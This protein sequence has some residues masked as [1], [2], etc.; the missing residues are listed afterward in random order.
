MQG[1]LTLDATATGTTG[2]PR[3]AGTARLA[4]GSVQDYAQGVRVTDITALIVAA[5]DTVRIQSF[6]GHAGPG[7][8]GLSGSV[9]VLAPGLPVD[10][11]LTAQNARPLASDLLTATLNAAL[12]VH[13][14]ASTRLDADGTVT[15]VRADITVPSALPPSVARLNVI[16]P[17]QKPPAPAA[18]PGLVVGLD[19]TAATSG[20]IFV[21][22]H[23]LDAEL[24]GRLH[25]AGTTAAPQV[26]GGFDMRRG[27]FSLAGTTL[28]FTRGRVGFDGTGVN[29]KI[30]PTLDF[31]ADSSAGSTTAIL[32]V[33]GY[34]DA[35]KIALS[36]TPELP[37]DEVLAQL[38][39]GQ[40]IKQLSPFQI[41]QIA[42]A[43]AELSGVG[44]GDD[45]LSSLRKGLGLDRLSVG[46]TSSGSGAS[47]QAGK[48]VA[49]GVYVGA[50]EGTDG[51]TQAQVQ[52]DLTRH[53]KL[54]S[55]LGAGGGVPAT[56]ITPQNDPGSS[57]G[58]KYQFEY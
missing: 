23:G 20:P 2:A 54:E 58:L 51:G 34:A 29:N 44:G 24:G 11:R 3:L 37:Q 36:S 30:D 43:L 38:L 42:S 16:R 1:T 26:S 45:V 52:V 39:F 17:G 25:V 47:L 14:Q 21:R 56:G 57:V 6:T 15:V 19:V 55:Q 50:K 7:T 49:R 41:A 27:T 33:T 53:L 46:G 40:S 10:L 4:G 31:E 22:G 18:G 8:I 48:Y 9:G 5:G 32:K 12:H 35:P 13:G 28:T